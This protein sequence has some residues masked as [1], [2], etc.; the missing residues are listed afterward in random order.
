MSDC[1]E[2]EVSLVSAEVQVDLG[3]IEVDTRLVD[4]TV[5]ASIEEVEVSVNLAPIEVA[6]ELVGPRG[7]AGADGTVVQA[8]TAGALSGHRVVII[9]DG[10]AS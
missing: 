9:D 8:T 2:I 1:P 3:A 7:P 6:V 4:V 10:V 5:S